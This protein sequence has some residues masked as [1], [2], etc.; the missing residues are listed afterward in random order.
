MA[1][2]GGATY[3]LGEDPEYREG[4]PYTGGTATFNEIDEFGEFPNPEYVSAVR[5]LDPTTGELQWQYQVQVKSTSG[6]LSTSGNLV[7]GGTVGG[8]FFAL[9]A[10]SGKELWRLDVGGTVHAAPMT[11]VVNGEQYVTIAAGSAL[12]TFGL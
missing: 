4:R 5:A 2:D 6:L 11:Y 12:F 7:F 8:N 3:Y 10:E 9:D 1:F